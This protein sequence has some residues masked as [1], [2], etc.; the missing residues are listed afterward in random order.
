MTK[1]TFKINPAGRHILTIGRD[2]IQDPYAA[3][4]ELVKNAYDADASHVNISFKN[5][6]KKDGLQIVIEDDGHGMTRDVVTSKWMVP[7]TNDKEIRKQ[8]PKGRILQGRKGIGRYASSI[9][10]NELFMETT[11]QERHEKTFLLV[12]WDDFERAEFLSD[13][14]IQIDTQACDGAS[15]TIL[16]I[17]GDKS[18]LAE[19]SLTQ[20]SRLKRELKKLMTPISDTK[21]S[22]ESNFEII[23]NVEGFSE[24]ETINEKI[25]PF[26]LFDLFDYKIAGY[27]EA[28]GSG[29]L[30]YEMQKLRNAVP[31]EIKFSFGRPTNCGRV[32]F[33][34]RVFDREK[35]AIEGLIKRGLK[36]EKG[37]YVG[38][39]E[40]RRLLN[41]NNGIG[42]YRN[43]FRIRPLGDPNFDWLELNKNR[44]QNPSRKIGSDQV[45]GFVKIESEERSNLIE[46]S[47]RDGLKDNTSYK[48]L[49]SL[50]QAIISELETRRFIHRN[51]TGLSRKILKVESAF[52]KLF[53]FDSLKAKV[54]ST[55]VK[56]NV[57]QGASADLIKAIEDVEKEKNVIAEELRNTIAVYQGQATL[58]KIVNVVLHEGRKPL[59][60]FKNQVPLFRSCYKKYEEGDIT[61]LSKIYEKIDGFASNSEALVLLF[62]KIDPLAVG[63]R[64]SKQK[65]D[66]VSCLKSMLEFCCSQNEDV[67]W[68]VSTTSQDKVYL[69]CWQQ[70]LYSIFTNLIEN[71]LYWMINKNA[72]QKTIDVQIFVEN[73]IVEYIDYRDSGPGIEESLLE[74]G[75]IFE[76]DFSTKKDGTGLGLSI[77]GEAAK[78]NGFELKALVSELGAHFR[79]ELVKEE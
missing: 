33:D 35:E 79:M 66:V 26:P 12:E 32:Q 24:Y 3:V 34:I 18:F 48:S 7:S 71:S 10:G 17:R 16:T 29:S 39:L 11:S 51:K 1:G 62:K 23:L 61:K 74:S 52:E 28:N 31:E 22:N 47:A 41:E 5:D 59:E 57:S 37:A 73:G 63:R 64:S 67:I 60:F 27:V 58:G 53:S 43:G 2:L 25:E 21:V 46:K 30:I 54:Q 44:V 15:G 55:L 78:R 50:T 77:A 42:V 4:V 65:V 6:H 14:E 70:D 40:A 76:P 72:E 38:S 20:F 13:V 19:W 8:S 45:I 56:E 75:V 36:D 69:E 9:L 68:N 49:V